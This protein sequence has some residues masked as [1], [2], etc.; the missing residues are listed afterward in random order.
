MTDRGDERSREEQTDKDYELDPDYYKHGGFPKFEVAEPGPGFGR[1]LT[2]MRRVQAL[3]E[4]ADPATDPWTAAAERAE[5][6]VRL[7][8]EFEAPEGVGR[9][10][11]FRAF[12]ARAVC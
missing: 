7:L 12:R 2:A 9:P 3:A 5:E 1:F 6:L 4:S 10:I 11:V 8:E